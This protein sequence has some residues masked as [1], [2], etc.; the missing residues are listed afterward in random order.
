MIKTKTEMKEVEVIEKVLCDKCKKEIMDI[1]EWQEMLH[2]DFV[3]GYSS[4]FGDGTRVQCNLCQY[5][6]KELINNFYQ[7]EEQN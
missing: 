6:L 3:G 2:I 7:K 1:L 4:V 5:C